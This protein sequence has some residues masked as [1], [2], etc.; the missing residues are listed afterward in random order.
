[1]SSLIKESMTIAGMINIR[2]K[3]DD[4][5]TFFIKKLPDVGM[6]VEEKL[7]LSLFKV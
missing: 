3:V 1:M 4:K 7:M 5:P 6:P 2:K